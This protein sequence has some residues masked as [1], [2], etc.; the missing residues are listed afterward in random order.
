MARA[1]LFKQAK[2]TLA[3]DQ[4]SGNALQ[5]FEPE[6]CKRYETSKSQSIVA[7]QLLT[8]NT[9]QSVIKWDE[10]SG[11]HNHYPINTFIDSIVDT[12]AITQR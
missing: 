9:N 6:V 8:N 11:S 7:L 12:N 10:V 5:I 4:H 2:D 3:E 1:G